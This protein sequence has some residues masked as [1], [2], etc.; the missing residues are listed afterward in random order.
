MN[1]EGSP[2]AHAWAWSQRRNDAA[3]SPPLKEQVVTSPCQ[4]SL[5]H[6][7]QSALLS[8]ALPLSMYYS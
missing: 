2:A 7:T 6:F 4:L 5:C 1:G 3:R 8:S